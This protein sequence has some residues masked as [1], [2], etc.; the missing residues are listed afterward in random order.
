MLKMVKTSWSSLLKQT[1]W[2]WWVS[3]CQGSDGTGLQREREDKQNLLP[4]RPHWNTSF[5]FTAWFYII[6]LLNRTVITCTALSQVLRI[7]LDHHTWVVS[8]VCAQHLEQGAFW[9]LIYI[10]TWSDNLLLL[11]YLRDWKWSE[12]QTL[13]ACRVPCLTKILWNWVIKCG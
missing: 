3:V 1:P 4:P 5:A 7:I 13:K 2:Q 6:F 8:G 11:A 12:P 9:H 10:A